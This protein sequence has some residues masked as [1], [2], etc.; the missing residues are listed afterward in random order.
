[1]DVLPIG[2]S[3]KM[4]TFFRDLIQLADD[5]AVEVF[6]PVEKLEDLNKVINENEN[7]SSIKFQ[8]YFILENDSYSY[9]QARRRKSSCQ[10]HW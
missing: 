5:E 8:P 7:S 2:H 10:L 6:N 4:E 1:M 3:F 9:T